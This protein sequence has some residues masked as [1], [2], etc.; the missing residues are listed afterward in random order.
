[1]G[2][3]NLSTFSGKPAR[4]FKQAF[5]DLKKQ[6]ITSL[7]IDLRNN[8]GGL[9]DEAV[10]IANYFLPRGKTLVTTRGKIE[11]INMSYK[12]LRE[13]IDL[14]SAGEQL[15][16]FGFGNLGRLITGLGPRGDCRYPYLWKG[17]CADNAPLA[18]RWPDE[19][20][21]LQVLHPQRTL[22]AGH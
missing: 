17:A 9:L 15:F 14:D 18:L 7:V 4:E 8:G 3:I 16:G 21:D 1:M 11:Q 10:D 19:D 22:C 5:L 2:Y 20:N 13:P 6:G 12:T